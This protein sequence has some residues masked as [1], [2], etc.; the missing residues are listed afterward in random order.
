MSEPIDLL[1]L[2]AGVQS[3]TLALLPVHDILPKPCG[4]SFADTWG[5]PKR[6]YLWLRDLSG[7]DIEEWKPNHWRAVPGL[8]QQG[9]LPYPIQIVSRGDLAADS[10]L[11]RRTEDGRLYSRTNIPFFTRDNETGALGKIRMRG[12][13]RDFKL[14]PLIQSARA[15]VA[16]LLP[17]WR[18]KHRTALKVLA[19]WKR[20]AKEARKLKQPAPPFPH[21]AFSECQA[22]ALVIQW[23]GISTDEASRMKPSRD[24]WIRCRWPLIEL[25]MSRSDC[26]KWMKGNGY[27]TP[28]RSAC[29]YCPF[30]GNDEWI[31][32]RDDEPMEFKKAVQF[33]RDLQVAK[34]QSSNFKTTPFLHRSCVPLDKVNFSTGEDSAQLNMFEN[35][36]EGM[37]GV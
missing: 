12:C 33:E 37:C 5:E 22:D 2:G 28:P 6:V 10:L 1:S 7:C 36:C 27:P 31:R 26:I 9:I 29:V 16:A 4:G 13:T 21:D 25:G 14:T 18:K 19:R 15:R 23:I 11:M 24:P 34:S 3:S 8:Y 20:E 35:E 30:H 32:L 17:S